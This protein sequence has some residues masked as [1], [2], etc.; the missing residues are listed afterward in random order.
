[1]GGGEFVEGGAGA[2][3]GGDPVPRRQRG[4]GEGTA[5]TAARSGDEPDAGFGGT[6]GGHGVLLI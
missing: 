5:E 2:R 1:M 3:G 6:G 4:F